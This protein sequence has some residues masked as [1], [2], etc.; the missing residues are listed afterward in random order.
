MRK[1][2]V[3]AFICASLIHCGQNSET[4]QSVAV[5]EDPMS[6]MNEVAEA[7]VKTA[8]TVGNHDDNYIDAYYGPKEWR[9][10]A[11]K[12]K[13]SLQDLDRQA[14]TLNNRLHEVDPSGLEPIA[15]QRWIFLKKQL[16]ALRGRVAHL[17][18]VKIDFNQEAYRLY[19]VYPPTYDVSHFETLIKELD[20]MLPG[21]GD[22]EKRLTEFKKDFIIPTDKLDTVFK[23]AI[24]EARKRTAANMELPEGESF[25][26]EYVTDKSWSGYNWYKGN[27]HSLIQ[28]NTDLPI[29]IDRAIDL[30][31]HEGY[32]GHH[33]YNASLEMAMYKGR[34][35]V[36]F[37][38]YPLF[39]PQSLIAE[40]SANYGIRVAFSQKERMAFE[41]ETL[42]PLAG[43]DPS[44]VE[45]YY[46][47]LD[48]VSKLNYAGNEAA[49][50]YLDGK[51]TREE[52]EAWLVKYALSAPE[53]AKQ[54]VTFFDKYRSYV[55]NYNLGQDIVADY[56]TRNGGTD[57]DPAKRWELFKELL[58]TPNVPSMLI[59]QGEHSHDGGE[60]HSH[61]G[62]DSHSHDKKEESHGDDA[63]KEHS[64][65][66]GKKHKH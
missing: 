27:A 66:D 26:L 34:N 53:R 42:F 39:S 13:A 36:E 57:E 3:L 17:G 52:A 23:A 64:H 12:S 11:K 22:L 33:V 61:D 51:M 62:G 7:F 30:A 41:K 21:E 19:D 56:I 31:C 45:E 10:E 16:F 25:D 20:G 40:G 65:A 49:R 54:R 24:A 50:A 58:S 35:W 4:T 18:G 46:K 37:S 32:P 9:E 38:V 5:T 14:D 48:V 6:I 2:L 15:Q 8:L 1:G 55:I 44:R 63:G 28:I 60:V 59:R 29:Y 43:L 47:V